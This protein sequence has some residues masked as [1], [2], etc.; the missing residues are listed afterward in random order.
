MKVFAKAGESL[1]QVGGEC[2]DGW[3]VMQEQRPGPDFV[4]QADGSWSASQA[5]T[6]QQCTPAQGLVALFAL[7]QI[8]ESDV[9]AAIEQIADPVEQYTA[10]ISYQRATYW[11]RTSAAMLQMAQLL[12][13]SDVDLDALFAYAVTVE[14]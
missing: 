4:A 6:P 12:G 8:K 13:L 1:Q 14:V 5:P 2:P 9:L 7:K 3:V 11:S 10:Q